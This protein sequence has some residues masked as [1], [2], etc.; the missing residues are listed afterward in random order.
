MLQTF[1]ELLRH[2]FGDFLCSVKLF[3]YRLHGNGKGNRQNHSRN[4]PYVPPEKQ[5]NNNRYRID[6]ERFTHKNRFQDA[7][8]QKLNCDSNNNEHNHYRHCWQEREGKH[9]HNRRGNNGANHLNEIQH[10]CKHAP[11]YRKR[12]VETIAQNAERNACE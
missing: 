11:E 5:H 1:L 2:Q 4:I 7:T 8:K 12:H 10:K 9:A 6:R 3:H